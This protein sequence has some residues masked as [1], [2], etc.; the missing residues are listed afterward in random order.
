MRTV[1]GKSEQIVRR[2]CGMGVQDELVPD[3]HGEG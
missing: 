2:S 1:G 3:C